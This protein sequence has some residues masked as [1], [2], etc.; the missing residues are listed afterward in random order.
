MLPSSPSPF[1]QPG[2]KG[3]DSGA[4]A[5]SQSGSRFDRL[6]KVLQ[7]NQSPDEVFAALMPLLG[8]LLGC[9]RC[10]LYLR[11]PDTGL[12]RVP[13]CWRRTKDV[14]EVYDA[15]WKAEPSSLAA[16]DPLFA[17]AL[18][19]APSIFVEDVQSAPPH[20]VNP[21]FER[22]NFGHRAL[23]H[24]HLCRDGQLWGVLQPCV[25]DRPRIWK[26]GDRYLISH[27]VEQITPLA[28]Q[29]VTREVES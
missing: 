21:D 20:L 12:G 9:H 4:I 6:N 26:E 22:E 28:I 3:A 16:E 10:F 5:P 24:A 14:P 23:V 29:Y 8:E 13:F 19:T 1:S 15:D 11:S 18:R 25:F 27:V 2:R 17:A 7:G